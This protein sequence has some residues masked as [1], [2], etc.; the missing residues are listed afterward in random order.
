MV[1]P[2]VID[3]EQGEF[4]PAFGPEDAEVEAFLQAASGVCM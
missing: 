1:G 4:P 3:R 2:L